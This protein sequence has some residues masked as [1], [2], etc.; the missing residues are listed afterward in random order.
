MQTGE[1]P[2]V[3]PVGIKTSGLSEKKK[4]A[5]WTPRRFKQFSIEETW[6][7]LK[8][9][10]LPEFDCLFPENHSADVKRIKYATYPYHFWGLAAI[11]ATGASIF[12]FALSSTSNFR[13]EKG[14]WWQYLI[15]VVL[16]LVSAYCF[17]WSRVEV[18]RLNKDRITM[19]SPATYQY[20]M[21]L[22]RHIELERKLTDVAAIMVEESGERIGDVDT[23][24]YS[25]RFEFTDGNFTT[26]LEQYSKKVAIRRCRSLNYLLA[27]YTAPPSP[28]KGASPKKQ[29]PSPSKT[30]GS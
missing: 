26:M 12:V 11:F 14:F 13:F 6:L 5:A 17:L 18:F 4:A 19:C 28:V 21:G 29:L 9:S 20:L 10:T 24:M 25:I 1:K 8:K 27:A 3:R 23:R 22:T 2:V 30:H 7:P 15:I 16:Y